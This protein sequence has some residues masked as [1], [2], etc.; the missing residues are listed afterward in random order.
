MQNCLIW[1]S[2]LK[3]V[4]NLHSIELCPDLWSLSFYAG[5]NVEGMSALIYFII[6]Y[7]EK[8]LSLVL[9]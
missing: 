7:F 1:N 9:A 5:A 2:K 6:I 4:Y 8:W 3:A